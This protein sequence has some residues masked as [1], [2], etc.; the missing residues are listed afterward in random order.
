[1]SSFEEAVI[2]RINQLEREVERLK[3]WERPI[4]GGGVTDHGSLSGL[5][6]D[7]HTQYLN[8]TRHDT[9]DRHT[10][11]TVVP[12]DDHGSLSGLND[13]D[14]PQYLLRTD[15]AADS[16]KL[17]GVDIAA[18]KGLHSLT[19]PNA[20]RVLFWDDSAGALKWLTVEGIVD[21]DLGKWQAYTP[22][23]TASTTNPAIGNG[24]LTGRYIVIGKLCT[25]VLGMVMGS[26]TTY[27][28]GDWAF[29]LPINAMKTA[30]INFYGVAHLRKVGTANYER[31]AEIVPANSVSV[32]NMFTDPTQGSNSSKI[33]ATVPFTWGNGDA[34]GFEITYEVA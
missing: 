32:I 34:L 18:F 28:S 14:H 22:K 2:Q 31:I 19:D 33:S 13:D 12:H 10:L 27:G 24:T 29:S 9:T 21:T 5:N 8:T 17:D 20:D 16:D 25:Y 30:G 15:K 11:G 7:D 26:T 6:D 1:V 3:R 4:G 23:W